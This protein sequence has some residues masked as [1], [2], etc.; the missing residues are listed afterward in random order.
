MSK[1][2]RINFYRTDYKSY[3]YG[4]KDGKYYL[5]EENEGWK[6][7]IIWDNGKIEYAHIT[8]DSNGR[9]RL[10]IQSYNLIELLDKDYD[11]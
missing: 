4:E 2:G 6:V 11:N 3:V 8:Y 9:G 5:S 10:K 7:K 1:D